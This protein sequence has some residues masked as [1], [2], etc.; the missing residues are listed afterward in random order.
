M[1]PIAILAAIAAVL[2]LLGRLTSRTDAVPAP[3]L[4]DIDWL[5]QYRSPANSITLD[6][7]T[8][9]ASTWRN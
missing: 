5:G 4:D 1:R 9:P 8:D 6:Y 7:P 3:A 2:I